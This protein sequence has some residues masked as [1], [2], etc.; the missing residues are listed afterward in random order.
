M[1]LPLLLLAS[2]LS[3][4]HGELRL[5]GTTPEACL[6]AAASAAAGEAT[7]CTLSEGVHR[8]IAS[9]TAPLRGPLTIRGAAGTQSS[10]LSGAL[11][12]AAA[13][14][15]RD[16]A[17]KGGRPIFVTT[18]PPTESAGE[19]VQVFVDNVFVS[20]ARWP[21]ANL[22]TVL[23]LK[24]WAFTDRA[25]KVGTIVDRA[26]GPTSVSGRSGLAASGID[27]TGA[28]ATLNIGDRFTTYVRVVKN[29]SA[30]SDRFDYS[31][32][33]GPGPGA[34]P[35]GSD[36]WGAG[37][38]YWLSGKKAALDAPG[39]WFISCES[40]VRP[41]RETRELFI[42]TPDSHPPAGRVSVKVKDYCIDLIGGAGAPVVLE[43]MAMHGCTFRLRQCDNCTVSG[44]NV[45]YAS[46]DPT[47]K[48]RN[49]P[50]GPPP[51]I[52]VLHGNRSRISDLHLRWANNAGLKIVG[53]DNVVENV[54]IEDVDWLGTLDFPALEVGFDQMGL[55]PSAATTERMLLRDSNRMYPRPTKGQ[56]NTIRKARSASRGRICH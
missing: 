4:T 2:L 48:I 14:W 10:T 39:E 42:W 18:L 3:P 55:D 22:S 56:R 6:L 23:S 38:R 52:T 25:S 45:S 44:L 47:I 34:P 20:E 11:P 27:W 53:D 9:S 8:T 54:L 50:M 33:L 43:N 36:K 51:N 26:A 16:P 29:H 24:T 41:L 7:T 5:E 1:Y 31:S 17:E 30:G 15:R 19:I 12:V 35:A 13:G 49:T 28:R 46:Y 21:D 32:D 40:L 37:G